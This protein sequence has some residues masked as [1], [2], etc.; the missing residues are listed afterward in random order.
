[1]NPEI[2]QG[3]QAIGGG[4]NAEFYNLGRGGL[5]DNPDNFFSEDLAGTWIPWVEHI[6]D[7]NINFTNQIGD[8]SS[9]LQATNYQILPCQTR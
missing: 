4:T 8:K 9:K 1:V 6:S 7:T 2:G 3:C 5:P